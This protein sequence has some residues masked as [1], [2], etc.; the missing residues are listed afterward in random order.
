MLAMITPHHASA[1]YT[2]PKRAELDEVCCPVIQLN[3]TK[4]LGI[5]WNPDSRKRKVAY[6]YQT[7]TYKQYLKEM[8]CQFPTA[9]V[10]AKIQKEDS[11]CN[12]RC[13]QHHG[14]QLM[15][16]LQ[17]SPLKFSMTEI[18]VKTACTFVSEEE[19]EE[20]KEYK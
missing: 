16:T 14:S 12:G 3:R 6:L 13:V 19:E 5:V 4:M 20:Y 8:E 18:E 15:I 10:P 9:T 17:P 11:R 1:E 7:S 2:T